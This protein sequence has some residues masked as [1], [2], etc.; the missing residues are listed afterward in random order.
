[1]YVIAIAMK[2]SLKEKEENERETKSISSGGLK[3][4]VGRYQPKL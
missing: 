4:N 3:F 1:M 2:D